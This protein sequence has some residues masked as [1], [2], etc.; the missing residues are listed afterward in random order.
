MTGRGAEGVVVL[1]AA[2][3]EDLPAITAVYGHNV[4]TGTGTF[5]T[6]PPDGAEMGRRFDGIAALGLPWLVAEVDGRVAGYAYAGPFRTRPAYRYTAET[7]LYVGEGATGHGVGKALLAELLTRCEA[8][9]LRQMLAVIG[10]SDNAASIALHAALGF[11]RTGVMTAV[12][13]KFG[14]WLDV[15]FMQRR[16]RAGQDAPPDAGGMPLA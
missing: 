3:T 5:E 15:V 12:G 11:E 7:S 14:R 2:T 13:W 16:L 10:D 1:R 9:G 6:T 8:L 4:L